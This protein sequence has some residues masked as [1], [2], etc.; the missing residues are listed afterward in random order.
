MAQLVVMPMMG[1]RLFSGP[2]LMAGGSRMG[3]LVFGAVLGALYGLP[4]ET[5][6]SHPGVT[7]H[8]RA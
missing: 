8:A 5:A 3:H 1:A 2:I 7:R 4:D 6:T